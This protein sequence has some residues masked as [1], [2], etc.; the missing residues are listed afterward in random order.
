MKKSVCSKCSNI[1]PQGEGCEKSYCNRGRSGF[2]RKKIQD[3][4]YNL[5]KKRAESIGFS[6]NW[7]GNPNKPLGSRGGLREAQ[8]L[9]QPFCE[10]CKE[11]GVLNDVTG[12]SQ[13]HVDHV[14]PFRSGKT[15]REQMK[16]F[17]SPDNHRTL[18]ES[19]HMS[20]TGRG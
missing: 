10:E 5:S 18:C 13:G 7:K 19:H 1:V 4:W 11:E 2:R 16:L 14:I 3:P 12:T 9:R 15:L 20:K 6:Q 8:I 17:E